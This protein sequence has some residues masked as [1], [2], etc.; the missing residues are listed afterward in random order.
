[1]SQSDVQDVNRENGILVEMLERIR[2]DQFGEVVDLKDRLSKIRLIIDFLDE[3]IEDL[4]SRK[5][6]KA[7]PQRR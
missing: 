3:K 1:M 5:N 4:K 2:Q 6:Q 7:P